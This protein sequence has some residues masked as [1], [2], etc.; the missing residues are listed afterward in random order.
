MELPEHAIKCKIG[1]AIV[2][3]SLEETYHLKL[4]EQ[5]IY[6]LIEETALAEKLYAIFDT[7]II[8]Y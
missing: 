2:E 8:C 1:G 6:E 4:K 5:I 3:K 7:V